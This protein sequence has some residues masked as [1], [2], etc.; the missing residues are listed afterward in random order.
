MADHSKFNHTAFTRIASVD[1]INT[2]ITDSVLPKEE[3]KK[4]QD[5][6]VRIIYT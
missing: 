2:I 4:Y 1:E 6:G 3:E 5:L